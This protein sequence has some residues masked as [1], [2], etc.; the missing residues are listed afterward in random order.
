MKDAQTLYETVRPVPHF[1]DEWSIDVDRRAG[2]A[3]IQKTRLESKELK[4]GGTDIY[5]GSR[6]GVVEYVRKTY[7]GVRMHFASASYVE[8]VREKYTF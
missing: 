3:H 8:R 1:K 2:T 4:K 6:E 7:P 5:R